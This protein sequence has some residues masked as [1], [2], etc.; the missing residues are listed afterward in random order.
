L[1]K[2]WRLRSLKVLAQS[3]LAELA[4]RLHLLRKKRKRNDFGDCQGWTTVQVLLLRFVMK[5]QQRSFLRLMP[6]VVIVHRLLS[7]YL[8][9]TKKKKKKS[10]L[11]ARTTG[12][13]ELVRGK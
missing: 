9:R 4:A 12:I 1:A 3:V 5:C 13:T 6:R 10:R 8:M 11:S 7:V 2:R